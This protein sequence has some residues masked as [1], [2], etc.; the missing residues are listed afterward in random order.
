MFRLFFT[1]KIIEKLLEWINKYIELY[2]LEEEARFT[3]KWKYSILRTI[4]NRVNNLF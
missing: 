4:F 3:Y 2:P 1:N